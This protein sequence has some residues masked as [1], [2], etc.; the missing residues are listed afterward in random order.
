MKTRNLQQF[1]FKVVVEGTIFAGTRDEAVNLLEASLVKSSCG[2]K[3]TGTLKD[4]KVTMSRGEG[5]KA[6][7]N[8]F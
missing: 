1:K 2:L 5:E 7:K 6:V 4:F 3:S 8:K